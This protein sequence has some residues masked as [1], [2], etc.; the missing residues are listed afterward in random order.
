[1]QHVDY[2]EPSTLALRDMKTTHR[3]CDLIDWS[4]VNEFI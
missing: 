3:N 1:M 4:V 2:G